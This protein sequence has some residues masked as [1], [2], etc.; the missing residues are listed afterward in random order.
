M[1]IFEI[2]LIL[3]R[4]FP[5]SLQVSDETL[6]QYIK[7]QESARGVFCSLT[8]LTNASAGAARDPML[9]MASSSRRP[10]SNSYSGVDLITEE[11]GPL[12]TISNRNPVTEK[13][14]LQDVT[15]KHNHR[16]FD[17]IF[18]VNF[19]EFIGASASYIASGR[20]NTSA[21]YY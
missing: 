16:L 17:V 3:L 18:I 20:T 9:T 1:F 13:S 6:T 5:F 7:F 4:F 11:L 14:G 8:Y 19:D 12:P 10:S 21:H 15:I 2:D